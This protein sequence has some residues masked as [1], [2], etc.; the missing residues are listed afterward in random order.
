M[1]KIWEALKRRG[2]KL[3]G[4]PVPKPTTE[5]K[6]P[7]ALAVAARDG[8]THD[9]VALHGIARRLTPLAT[10]AGGTLLLAYAAYQIF[11]LF[12]DYLRTGL[13]LA[14]FAVVASVGVVVIMFM[15]H[16]ESDNRAVLALSGALYFGWLAITMVLVSLAAAYGT[17][18]LRPLIPD[19]LTSMGGFSAVIL[20]ASAV[21]AVLTLWL[22]AKGKLGDHSSTDSARHAYFAFVQKVVVICVSMFGSFYFGMSRN[23]PSVVAVFCALVLETC[24]IVSYTGLSKAKNELDR[25]NGAVHSIA[26]IVFGTFI[27][28]VVINSLSTVA[29]IK[30]PILEP[31]AQAGEGLFIS[32]AG[33][34][35]IYL[36]VHHVLNSTRE[37]REG[38]TGIIEGKVSR[39]K[40]ARSSTPLSLRLGAKIIDARRA[41]HAI[42]SAF[43]DPVGNHPPQQR[44]AAPVGSYGKDTSAPEP[45]VS[46]PEPVPSANGTSEPDDPK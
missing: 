12:N 37:I 45:T 9:P 38:E 20:S 40:A 16:H 8:D 28:L 2:D 44:L 39:V 21:A 42:V 10:H 30:L 31:L 15:A 43:T 25:L 34:A 19:V 3:T 41:Y 46:K 22:A 32:S 7:N 36:I 24:F 35:L 13:L 17:P 29:N 23:M 1:G 33:L 18:E 4:T 5:P 6:D 27:G 14:C 11:L 26:E